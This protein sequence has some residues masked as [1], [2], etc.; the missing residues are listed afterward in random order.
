LP[1]L[2]AQE[3]PADGVE[4]RAIA[5]S[6]DLKLADGEIALAAKRLGITRPLGILSELELGAAA[7][8]ET[9][10]GWGVGPAFTLPIPIFSQGQPAVATAAAQLRQ[11]EQ[12][13]LRTGR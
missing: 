3:I 9:T 6:L 11:A 7:E 8:R 13:L 10:G 5:Q 4:R 12:K 1:E 2:P